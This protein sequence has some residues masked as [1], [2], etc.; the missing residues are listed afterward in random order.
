MVFTKES[1]IA[2]KLPQYS[3][4]SQVNLSWS[5]HNCWS[6]LV[7]HY[8]FQTKHSM[9]T[10]V[11][12]DSWGIFTLPVSCGCDTEVEHPMCTLLFPASWNPHHNPAAESFMIASAK[13]CL[14]YAK[15]PSLDLCCFCCTFSLLPAF[16]AN[17]VPSAAKLG[18]YFLPHILSAHL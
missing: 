14:F 12:L 8:H 10:E 11:V 2:P 16:A 15:C 13:V 3:A 4:L 18:A 9:A 17:I 1:K 7:V 5:V 6:M